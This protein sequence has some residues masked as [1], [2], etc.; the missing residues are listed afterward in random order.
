MDFKDGL[1]ESP[2]LISLN[3]PSTLN[4]LYGEEIDYLNKGDFLKENTV[5]RLI[6]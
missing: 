2:T 5:K 6:H 3:C 4:I 1:E